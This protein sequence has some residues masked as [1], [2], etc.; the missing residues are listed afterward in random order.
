MLAAIRYNLANLVNFKGRDSR[1][2]FW[3]YV[4]FLVCIQVAISIVMSIAMVGPM[5]ADIF[6]AAQRNLPPDQVQQQIYGHIADMTH[7]SVPIYAVISV[8]IT[9]MLVAAFTRR[10]HD[11]DKPGWIAVLLVVLQLAS[12]AIQLGSINLSATYLALAQSGDVE[13][14]RSA[15]ASLA[16]RQLL[17][18]VPALV[19]VVFG[20][21]PSSDGPNRYGPE[22]DVI[23]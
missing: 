10:L 13:Q 8:I 14:M 3:F 5:M 19:I 6:S 20:A 18:W 16:W 1:Q 21:W 2:T 12:I 11:S 7:T 17:S 22:P 9:A 4:L 15:Q 23:G